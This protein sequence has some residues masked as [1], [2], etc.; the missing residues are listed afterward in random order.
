MSKVY[1]PNST[2]GVRNVIFA[3]VRRDGHATSEDASRCIRFST[4]IR[5]RQK[6]KSPRYHKFITLTFG[7][8]FLML[9]IVESKSEVFGV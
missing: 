7:T 6:I 5:Y 3:E 9:F 8:G 4:P 1:Q 2:G